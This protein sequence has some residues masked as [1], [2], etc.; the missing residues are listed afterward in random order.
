MDTHNLEAVVRLR[1]ALHQEP[2]ISGSE[3]RTAARILDFFKPLQPDR[4]V[5]GLGGHGLAFHFEGPRA[6]PTILLRCEL[7]AL[8]I[9]EANRVGHRS[10]VE[11]VSHQC[12]H[13]GHMSI[14]A[15]VGSQLSARRPASGRVILLFQPEEETGAGAAKVVLDPRFA[16][17]APTLCFALHNVP[18]YPLGEV[19]VRS[20]SMASASRGMCIQLQ[21]STAHAAHPEAGNSPA[22]ALCKLIAALSALP[23]GVLPEAEMGFITVVGARLGEKAFGTAPGQAE[24]WATLRAETNAGMQRLITYADSVSGAFS[25][26]D[27]LEHQRTF[28]DIFPATQNTAGAVEILRRAAAPSRVTL[29][30]APF[31][32]SEDFGHFLQGAEGA[33]FGLGSGLDTPQLHHPEY[34]FPEELIEVGAAIFGRILRDCLA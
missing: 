13:D 5:E 31:R 3:Q 11:G 14:L 4:I 27:G 19:L 32:W 28:E 10:R 21:G 23:A 6:G 1:R 30:E 26:L 34:D 22:N 20:G 7:D 25:A 24:I 12:G 29:L 16:E 17:H 8:P 2:E 33:L 9:Q 18:G 15:A